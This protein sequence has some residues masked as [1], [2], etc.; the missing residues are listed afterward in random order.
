MFFSDD[1]EWCDTFLRKRHLHYELISHN[2]GADSY[3]DMYLMTQCKHKII[4]N[5]TFSWWGAWL[6]GNAGK[7]VICPNVW[8]K[9]N[10]ENPCPEEWLHL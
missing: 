1:I 2:T 9:S 5:S 8:I 10:S 6:N 4:S 7:Q 3:K